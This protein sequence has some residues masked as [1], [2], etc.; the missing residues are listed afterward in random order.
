MSPDSQASAIAPALT[1][2]KPAALASFGGTNVLTGSMV[3][4]LGSG[5]VSAVNFGY[6]VIVARYLGPADFGQVSAIATM[7]MIASALT[8][9]FQLVCAKFVARNVTGWAKARVYVVLMKR[10][11]I[12]GVVCAAGLYLLRAP[13][14]SLLKLPSPT[15]VILLAVAVAFSLPMGVKRGG[16]QGLYSFRSL[17]GN[18]IL[19]SGAK[20]LVA[21]AVIY[22][23]FGVVGAVAAITAS[24]VAAYLFMPVRFSGTDRNTTDENCIPA[25]FHEGMQAIVFSVGQVIINNVDILLVKFFFDPQQAGLYAAVAL[26]GRLLYFASWQVVSAMFP[27]SASAKP[28]EKAGSVLATP[29][30]LVALMSAGFVTI[31]W[32]APTFI[33]STV[34]GPQFLEAGPLFGLYAA[35][36]GLYALSV[37]LMTY[38]MS[39]RIANTGWLQLV[40][41]AVMILGIGFFH[42]TLRQVI[43]VQ[44]VLMSLLLLLVSL[45]FLKRGLQSGSA[46]QEAA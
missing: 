7:L 12:G 4:L 36:T 37:V 35:A 8:I 41:S 23:G 33:I 16:L 32:L 18:F 29:M 24:V 30:L 11:W 14:S 44:I 1:L 22:L 9:S 27:I 28:G 38:E 13:I 17:S 45:P 21:I 42:D 40:F 19:E 5:V 20:F 39:R 6:N 3:M 15:L 43:V 31:L 10:A 25:S 34:F 2:R 46:L 26:V